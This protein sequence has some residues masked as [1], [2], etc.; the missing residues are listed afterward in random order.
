M[1][2]EYLDHKRPSSLQADLCRTHGH[3]HVYAHA[4]AHVYVHVYA[5][6]YAHARAHAYAHVCTHVCAQAELCSTRK[7][8]A[9]L[10]RA[11]ANDQQA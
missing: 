10:L 1:S 5:H 7:Q 2:L 9:L 6:V 4:Y 3:A 11:C 8:L